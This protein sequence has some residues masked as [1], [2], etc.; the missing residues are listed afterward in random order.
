MAIEKRRI[1][2]A[3]IPLHKENQLG[4]SGNA[5]VL[6]ISGQSVGAGR[7]SMLKDLPIP[8][9]PAR[10][11]GSFNYGLRKADHS[12][13]LDDFVWRVEREPDVQKRL[14]HAQRAIGALMALTAVNFPG[15]SCIFFHKDVFARLSAMT[16]ATPD[17]LVAM[18]GGAR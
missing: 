2:G 11:Y 16:G 8:D 5:V 12:E 17:Q 6:A 7:Q 9:T 1:S 18:A 14:M 13:I 4:F 15:A 10:L 3:G